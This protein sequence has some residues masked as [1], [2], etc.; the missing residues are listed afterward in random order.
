MW[1]K[2]VI[3]VVY[4][5]YTERNHIYNKLKRDT[6]TKLLNIVKFKEISYG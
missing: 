2:K 1:G 5:Y 3:I 6:R 4:Y